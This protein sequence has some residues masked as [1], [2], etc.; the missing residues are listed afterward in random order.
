MSL[1]L[2]AEKARAEALLCEVL[3]PMVAAQMM[4]GNEVAPGAYYDVHDAQLLNPAAEY[5][6]VTVMFSDV[7]NFGNIVPQTPPTEVVALLNNLFTQFDR[8][9]QINEVSRHM[10]VCAHCKVIVTGVQSRNDQRFIHASVRRARSSRKS[11]RSVL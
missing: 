5:S 7:P 4:L 9:V 3:P 10:H 11:R 1:E 6:E 2:E 8:L